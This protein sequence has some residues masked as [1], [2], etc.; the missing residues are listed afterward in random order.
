[1]KAWLATAPPAPSSNSRRAIKR[2]GASS[3]M[4]ISCR[5]FLPAIVAHRSLAAGDELFVEFLRRCGSE[6]NAGLISSEP[7]NAQGEASKIGVVAKR[8]CGWSPS[9]LCSQAVGE[10]VANLPSEVWVMKARFTSPSSRN[11]ID[12]RS[13][14]GAALFLTPRHLLHAHFCFKALLQ[15]FEQQH[16]LALR[17]MPQRS[18]TIP[19]L[20]AVGL[21]CRPGGSACGLLMR[22]GQAG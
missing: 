14:S 21:C 5:R 19:I 7:P 15:C 2:S 17:S 6:F 16:H 22:S 10:L 11:L 3:K 1:M 4:K 9:P 12:E 20:E 13:H 18:L 8:A